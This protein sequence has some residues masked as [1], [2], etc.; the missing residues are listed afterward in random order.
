MPRILR[1]LGCDILQG[2]AL[3]RPMDAERLAGFLKAQSWRAGAMQTSPAKP[4]RRKLAA[5]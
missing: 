5:R 4:R 1:D 3:A 2:Y